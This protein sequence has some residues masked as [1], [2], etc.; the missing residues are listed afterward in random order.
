MGHT[1]ERTRN[2]TGKVHK[3]NYL[4]QIS[5]ILRILLISN[6]L[7]KLHDHVSFSCKTCILSFHLKLK[8]AEDLMQPGAGPHF[9][10][11]M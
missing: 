1:Q 6:M 5:E 11:Q 9:R 3:K 8:V 2:K 4:I 7:L 10:P